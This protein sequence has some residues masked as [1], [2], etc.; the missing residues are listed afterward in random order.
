VSIDTRR[1]IL[2]TARA[3]FNEHGVHR[4]GVRDVARAMEMSPGNL[5]YHF[6]TKDRLVSALVVEVHELNARTVFAAMPDDF[7]P[8]D[9][10]AT[11]VA[12]MRNALAYRFVMLSYVDAVTASSELQAIEAK[13]RVA[14]R[15]R[16]D[17][18]ME[19]LAAGGW[20]DRRL[21]EP[22]RAWLDEQG[23]LVSAGWLADAALH[24]AFAHDDVGAVLHYAK[25]GCAL[26]EPCCTPKGRRAMRRVLAGE[27]DAAMRAVLRADP[28]T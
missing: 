15:R 23:R 22:R 7:G 27:H 14:R 8:R 12:A 11:A 28:A 21:V 13:L 1:R 26:L 17:A 19:R 9:L 3:L 4:V 16:T 18:M 25:V 20:L 10:Y 24:P 5:A 6:P 2:D